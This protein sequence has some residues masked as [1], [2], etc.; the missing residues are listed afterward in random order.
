MAM[1]DLCAPAQ[2][3]GEMTPDDRCGHRAVRV[4]MSGRRRSHDGAWKG[5]QR[6]VFGSVRAPKD[7]RLAFT[8]A[9]R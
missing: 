8:P 2:R 3:Q 1:A 4:R 7:L 5:S 9:N 6:F